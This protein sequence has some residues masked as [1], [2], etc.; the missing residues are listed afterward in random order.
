GR[1]GDRR[2]STRSG[3]RLAE[4]LAFVTGGGRG[5]GASVARALAEDGFSVVVGARTRP[6]V[7]TVAAEIGGRAVELDVSSPSSIADVFAEVGP[8][9]LLV[10]NAGIGG[11][12]SSFLEERPDEWWRV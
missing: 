9:D 2:Y 3:P 5:V 10:N 6:E 1:A 4:Q 11:P 8:V 7:D 12:S